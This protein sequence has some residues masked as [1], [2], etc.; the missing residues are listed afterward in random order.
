VFDFDKVEGDNKNHQEGTKK[1]PR[2]RGAKAPKLDPFT[3]YHSRI[4]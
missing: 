2:V 4:Y 3:R 1:R